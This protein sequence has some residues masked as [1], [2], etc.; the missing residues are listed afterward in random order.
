MEEGVIAMVK[1]V[2]AMVKG[3]GSANTPSMFGMVGV[4][5]VAD[6]VKV[7]KSLEAVTMVGV[8]RDDMKDS[9]VVTMLGVV[10]VGVVR[11]QVVM[12]GV[13]RLG[14][15]VMAVRG[16]VRLAGLGETDLRPGLPEGVIVLSE[17]E[18]VRIFLQAGLCAWRMK[19]N[20]SF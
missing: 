11:T 6:V 16:R 18:S 2:V 9:R 12:L 10:S 8:S 3:L 1:G 17:S 13:L 14:E 19:F 5:R 15:V 20:C 7:S 4:V